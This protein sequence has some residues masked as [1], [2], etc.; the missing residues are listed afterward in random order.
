MHELSM[1][2]VGASWAFAQICYY[3][4]ICGVLMPTS[5][6]AVRKSGSVVRKHG[7][8]TIC[9]VIAWCM[10]NTGNTLAAMSCLSH[11]HEQCQ[12]AGSA[13][14]TLVSSNTSVLSWQLE[15]AI[16]RCWPTLLHDAS[17]LQPY[18]AYIFLHLGHGLP[19]PMTSHT[20]PC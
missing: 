12:H 8:I 14:Q 7:P 2:V 18:R 11:G 1:Y 17:S 20:A 16:Q 10:G 5:C 3:N 19:G 13:T 9:K 15:W 6:R 4:T